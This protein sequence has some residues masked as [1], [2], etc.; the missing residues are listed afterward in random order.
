VLIALIVFTPEAITAL[1]AALNNQCADTLNPHDLPGIRPQPNGI[2][3][4]DED[5]CAWDD[6]TQFAAADTK[7]TQRYLI[8]RE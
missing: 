8:V 5:S 6:Q 7:N 3:G 4:E 2:A 1:R